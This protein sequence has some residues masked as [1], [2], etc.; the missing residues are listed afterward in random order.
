MNVFA[1]SFEVKDHFTEMLE[2]CSK[3]NHDVTDTYLMG[4]HAVVFFSV[5]GFLFCINTVITNK[6]PCKVHFINP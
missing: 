2:S 4:E 6:T 1:V 5:E 3:L